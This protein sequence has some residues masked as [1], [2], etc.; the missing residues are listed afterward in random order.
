MD[1]ENGP[2]QGLRPQGLGT[3]GVGCQSRHT[4][5]PKSAICSQT[6]PGDMI[7]I[8]S[9]DGH[10]PTAKLA[11]S[12]DHPSGAFFYSSLFSLPAPVEFGSSHFILVSQFAQIGLRFV[13]G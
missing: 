13:V 8:G 11:P 6:Q 1:K 12:A 7:R 4:I 2:S 3:R 9:V 5:K 10:L